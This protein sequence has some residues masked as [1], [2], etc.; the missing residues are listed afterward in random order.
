MTRGTTFCPTTSGTFLASKSELTP[1]TRKLKLKEKFWNSTYVNDCLVKNKTTGPIQSKNEEFNHI[2]EK[3]ENL[4][5]NPI[6]RKSNISS[7]EK[8]ALNQLTTYKDIIIKKADK[9]GM[10]VI[11]D[12]DFYR[13]KLVLKDHLHTNTY[14]TVPLNTDKK[15]M[16]NLGTLLDKHKT[17]LRPQEIDYIHNDNWKS[18]N[19][20]L[21]PKV[22]KNKE[23]IKACTNNDT[24][25]LHM[26]VPP[27]LK[28][29]PI[30]AGPESP[31]QRLSEL[32]E[33]ILSPLVPLLKSYVKDDWDFLRKL[34]RS[35]D[36]DCELY[37]VDIVSL[38]TSIPHDLG[39]EA[40][41][42]YIDKHRSRIPNRFTKEFILESLLFVLENN[43]FLFDGVLYHQK[44]GTAMGT[45][46]APPYAN[47]TVGY[48]EETKLEP[49]L[50]RHFEASICELIIRCFLRYID[51]GFIIWPKNIKIEI[52]FNLLNSL[53]SHIQFTI[54]ASVKREENGKMV[55]LLAF[56]DVL[57]ILLNHRLFSTDIFYKETNSHFYLNY[58]SHH[59]QHIK[60][61]LPY[62]LA[63][64]IVVFVSDIDQMNFR[65]EQ[66]KQWLLKCHYPLKIILKGI[67]NAKLQGPAPPPTNPQNLL[68]LT[69]TYTSNYTHEDNIH[70]IENLLKQTKSERI[71]NVFKDSKIMIAHKQPKNLLRIMTKAAFNS[72]QQINSIENANG[73]WKGVHRTAVDCKI[74]RL[75]IQECTSFVCSNGKV[76]KIP[77]RIDCHSKNLLYYLKCLWCPDPNKPETYTGKT[78]EMRPRMNNHAS[79]CRTGRSTNIF[80][81]HVFACRKKHGAKGDIEPFFHIYAFYTV[82]HTES[83]ETHEKNLHLKGYDTMN[84]PS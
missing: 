29:R 71:N 36:F 32:L 31:T 74:C 79:S 16:K 11:L 33:K 67:H 1:F 62:T 5:P 23:I 35:V 46:C 9:G 24:E 58:H 19:I 22:H 82:K 27:D 68:I 54:E 66:M 80:D 41:S 64:K 59:P 50:P 39:I 69:S 43:N 42:Y 2:I 4:S 75:Y 20:Y 53:N 63:K 78:K 45:K 25:Y 57:I 13:D 37:S 18:S 34:P 38:Y 28:G 61:N 3:I 83:L 60:D 51:D 26:P 17:C 72:S 6:R 77:S 81:K 7:K 65:L 76:W 49:Q 48:L 84:K 30:I 73:L 14:E 8:E 47:L 40:I 12:T 55:E 44:T 15:V 21:S 56:L 10:F 52:F 70:Q